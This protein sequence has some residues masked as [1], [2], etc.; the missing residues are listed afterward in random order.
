M[1]RQVRPVGIIKT[2]RGNIP[3]ESW[4]NFMMLNGM[5][6]TSSDLS[7]PE[8][9]EV[10][11]SASEELGELG[12]LFVKIR[13]LAIGWRLDIQTILRRFLVSIKVKEIYNFFTRLV[14]TLRTG[15]TFV[16]F[17]RIESS[18][19]HLSQQRSVERAEERYRLLSDA[20][21]SLLS[22]FLFLF[23]TIFIT[24]AVF[25]FGEPG[26]ILLSLIFFP[27][28]CT[29]LILMVR[30]V[31]PSYDLVRPGYKAV[32]RY[33][34]LTILIILTL[35]ILMLVSF[36]AN[37]PL[38]FVF[39]ALIPPGLL[40]LVAY[41]KGKRITKIINSIDEELPL[42]VSSL[43]DV[44]TSTG[45][46]IEAVSALVT[47]RWSWFMRPL[48]RLKSRLDIG[49]DFDQCWKLFRSELC[50]RLAWDILGLFAI[51]VKAGLVPNK[52][53]ETL[54]RFIDLKTHA[55]RIRTAIAGY[56]RGLITPIH[57]AFVGVT[58][59][60]IAIMD[61]FG[62]LAE[63][64]RSISG[65]IPLPFFTT[66]TMPMI[67][68]IYFVTS[69]ASMILIIMNSLFLG[70]LEGGSPLPVL[71]SLAYLLLATGIIG[72][73]TITAIRYLLAVMGGTW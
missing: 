25:G 7:F 63:S 53:S 2:S 71:R 14:R 55:R 11:S 58:L 6:A 68:F 1:I 52:F 15:V 4:D 46:I 5:L 37:L 61:I 18:M 16:D 48:R 27:L 66:F 33:N 65:S 56:A 26:H 21:S 41:N 20:Y 31:L 45:S 8:Y 38:I 28:T 51:G 59:I 43:A 10:L 69:A 57:C 70:M 60:L 13:S 72:F 17:L 62:S 9:V 3:R 32:A 73:L 12:R 54:L 67:S 22:S 34:H 42:F 23:I 44:T 19:Y 36:L 24:S 49:A 29:I 30:R 35:I 64:V 39:L 50:S 40:A 47:E